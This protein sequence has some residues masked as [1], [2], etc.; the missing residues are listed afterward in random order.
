MSR[1]ILGDLKI[2][3]TQ[4]LMENLHFSDGFDR[5]YFNC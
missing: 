4:Y 2:V 5:T 3:S 1:L